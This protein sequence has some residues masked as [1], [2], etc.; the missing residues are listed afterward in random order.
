M[1][2][3]GPLMTPST[4]DTVMRMVMRQYEDLEERADPR[5][6]AGHN[7]FSRSMSTNKM[8]ISAQLS[9]SSYS[10]QTRNSTLT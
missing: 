8:G 2:G 5:V 3:A 6:K 4:N 7:T 1:A 10:R 9:I